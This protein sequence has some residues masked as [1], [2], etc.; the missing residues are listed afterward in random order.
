MLFI[1]RTGLRV[2]ACATIAVAVSFGGSALPAGAA[3]RPSM[4]G[5][6]HQFGPGPRSGF[7]VTASGIG[8]NASGSIRAGSFH[9]K[10]TCLQVS[11]NDGVATAVI[12]SSKD[13][14][15]PPG[16]I[17][18]GEGVDNGHPSYGRSPDLWRLSFQDN[19]GI[20]FTGQPGC[21]FPFYAPVPIQ[22]G[23]IVVSG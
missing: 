16:E 13:P 12:D 23:N 6:A 21:W 15:F 10:V 20:G 18:V 2:I 19:A 5:G 3:A 7:V 11:G 1:L 17:I 9:A 22:M 8:N 14:A 4:H